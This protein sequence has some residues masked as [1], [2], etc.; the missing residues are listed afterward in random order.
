MS[1]LLMSR[2]PLPLSARWV[3]AVALVAA[4]VILTV[5]LAAGTAPA[6]A[7]DIIRHSVPHSGC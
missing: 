2:F 1:S 3:F 7:C 6:H 5:S 4:V